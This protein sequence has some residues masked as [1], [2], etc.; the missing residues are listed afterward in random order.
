MVRKKKKRR[1]IAVR[2][3]RKAVP[4]KKTALRTTKQRQQ[5]LEFLKTSST[6]STAEVIYQRL[7]R[8]LRNLT[9][10]TVHTN[11][12]VL[13]EAGQICELTLGTGVSCYDA[14][15]HSHYHFICNA[16]HKI[17]DIKIPPMK[18]LDERVGQL[19][20]FRIL[21]HRL[22]FFGLCDVCKVKKVNAVK[23]LKAR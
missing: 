9:L 4:I 17:Y 21:S 19:T 3:K 11:L 8:K 1:K 22:D 14:I 7:K 20:G 23:K 2:R 15:M 5:I 12:R 6:H 13:K 10:S 18:E 16:C